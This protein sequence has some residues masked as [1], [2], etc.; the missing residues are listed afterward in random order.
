MLETITKDT[1]FHE[2]YAQWITV[3][4]EGAIR[5]VTLNKYK[6]TQQW[7]KKTDSR[8]ENVRNDENCLSAAHQ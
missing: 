7:L 1:L 8:P 3:Y 2:Y 6:M 4:K 5:N